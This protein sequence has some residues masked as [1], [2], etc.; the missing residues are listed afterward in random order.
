MFF[1]IHDDIAKVALKWAAEGKIKGGHHEAMW[2]ERRKTRN[3][4]NEIDERGYSWGTI[5]RAAK[6]REERRSLDSLPLC[7]TRHN[8]D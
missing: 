1:A 4:E 2:D 7:A 8:K 5:E 3:L 6:S